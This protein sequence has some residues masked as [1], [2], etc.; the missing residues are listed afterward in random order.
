MGDLVSWASGILLA[1]SLA[2][3]AVFAV[4]DFADSELD[5]HDLFHFLIAVSFVAMTAA[6]FGACAPGSVLLPK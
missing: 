5:G 6:M 1:V 4:L 3:S 2:A